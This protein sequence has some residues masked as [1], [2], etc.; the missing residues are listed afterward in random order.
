LT[1]AGA[2]LGPASD[3]IAS[4]SAQNGIAPSMRTASSASHSPSESRT[5]PKVTASADIRTTIAAAKTRLVA[6]LP[7]RYASGGIGLARFTSSQPWPRSTAIPTPIANN[8]APTTPNVL[9]V[10]SRYVGTVVAP[11]PRDPFIASPNSA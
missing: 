9:Y 11:N 3:P 7:S 10:P 5:P 1:I 6:I 2:E 4:P 8:A